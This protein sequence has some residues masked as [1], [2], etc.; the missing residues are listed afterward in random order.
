MDKSLGQVSNIGD[1]GEV[2]CSKKI[3]SSEPGYMGLGDTRGGSAWGVGGV[4]DRT[5]KIS[6]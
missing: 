5:F 6:S 3:W 4:N 2:V 1:Q